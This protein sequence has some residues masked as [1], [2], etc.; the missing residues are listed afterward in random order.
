MT[1]KVI[2][3]PRSGSDRPAREPEP[4]AP[5]EKPRFDEL[6]RRH[7]AYIGRLCV[8][9]VGD[10]AEAEDIVQDTFVAAI[11]GAHTLEDLSGVRSWLTKIAVREC[12]RRMRLRR[13]RRFIGLDST[14]AKISMPGASPDQQALLKQLFAVLDRVPA[15]DRVC[16]GL[17]Y[18]HG[19][20]IAAIAEYCNCSVATVK[21][22]ITSTQLTIEEALGT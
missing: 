3:L 13:A 4:S 15:K 16:W 22:R 9:L 14:D 20:R 11:R 10:P 19:E 18:L 6:F 2:P 5:G 8:R 21:R 7:A 12:I 17:R 1:A